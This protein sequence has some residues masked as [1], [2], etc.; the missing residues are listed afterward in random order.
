M[1]TA[2][3]CVR[4]SGVCLGAGEGVVMYSKVSYILMYVHVQSR[5]GHSFPDHNYVVNLTLYPFPEHM[6]LINLPFIQSLSITGQLTL[7]STQHMWSTYPLPIPRACVVD[8]FALIQ[9]LSITGQPTLYP[10]YVVDLPITHSQSIC[11]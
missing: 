10:A 11:G 6:W 3:A 8:Q 1:H 5:C 4:A 9:S 7:S 2:H